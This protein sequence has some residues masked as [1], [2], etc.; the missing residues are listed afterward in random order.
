MMHENR[1]SFEVRS[2][3]FCGSTSLPNT[4]TQTLSL[5]RL[6]SGCALERAPD[7]SLLLPRD[8]LLLYDDCL[9]NLVLRS[10]GDVQVKISEILARVTNA[11]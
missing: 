8:P 7:G 10:H 5:I 2:T 1:I 9:C 4:D 3:T 6:C 11:T